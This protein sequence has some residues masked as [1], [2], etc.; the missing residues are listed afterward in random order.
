[1][2][3]E[4]LI[5]FFW[6]LTSI[7][8]IPILLYIMLISRPIKWLITGKYYPENQYKLKKSLLYKWIVNAQLTIFK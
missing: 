6:R 1:M 5:K 3:N 7:I 2:K 4:N 8:L